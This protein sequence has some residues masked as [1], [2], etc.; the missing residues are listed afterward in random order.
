MPGY[1]ID[2]KNKTRKLRSIEKE[3]DI[4][5]PKKTIIKDEPVFLF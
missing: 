2:E 1:K 4:E 5:V 3:T